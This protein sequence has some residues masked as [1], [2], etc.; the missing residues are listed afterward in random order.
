[1]SDKLGYSRSEVKKLLVENDIHYSEWAHW[2]TGQTYPIVD[3]EIRYYKH[4][5]E[6]FI[7]WKVTGKPTFFD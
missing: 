4:D 7:T 1:M 2:I 6:R 5:V 3:D